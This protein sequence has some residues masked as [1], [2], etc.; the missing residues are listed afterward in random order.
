[1]A[2]REEQRTDLKQSPGLILICLSK[3]SFF[4]LMIKWHS[5]INVISFVTLTLHCVESNLIKL[6]CTTI[7]VNSIIAYTHGHTSCLFNISAQW[8]LKMCVGLVS[9]IEMCTLCCIFFSLQ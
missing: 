5:L 7:A 1:M 6:H 2:D 4:L 8:Q 9:E 3:A